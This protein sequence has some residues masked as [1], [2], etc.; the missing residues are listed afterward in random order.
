[1]KQIFIFLVGM[2]MFQV[3]GSPIRSELGG[4]AEEDDINL[5]VNLWTWPDRVAPK[6]SY[7]PQSEWVPEEDV[8]Y[9]RIASNGYVS[10]DPNNLDGKSFSEESFHQISVSWYVAGR[11]MLL[12]PGEYLLSYD[13]ICETPSYDITFFLL[14]YAPSGSKWRYDRA[15]IVSEQSREDRG[16][17]KS[18]THSFSITEEDTLV[19]FW[20]APRSKADDSNEADIWN[21]WLEKIK[22]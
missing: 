20:L 5:P 11:F 7:N 8:W 3:V 9:V 13:Y 1:M 22:E 21:M 14:F 17:Y 4:I 16:W 2:L 18:Q 12:E 10:S 19:G 6:C 15:Q